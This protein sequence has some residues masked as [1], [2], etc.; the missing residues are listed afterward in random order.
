VMRG[1]IWTRFVFFYLKSF[2]HFKRRR[3]K[4]SF[5]LCMLFAVFEYK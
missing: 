2:L 3:K 1:V 5:F 4:N